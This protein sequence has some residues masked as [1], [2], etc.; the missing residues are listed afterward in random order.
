[1]SRQLKNMGFVLGILVVVLVLV[2][3]F[4]VMPFMKEKPVQ[5]STTQEE[6]PEMLEPED[7]VIIETLAEIRD[8]NAGE[9]SI[10]A[11]PDN[12]NIR[13]PFFWPEEKKQQVE[14]KETG[15]F[16][17]RKSERQKPQLSMVIVGE[18]R[19]KA[20]IDDVFVSEGDMFH[21]YLV[22]RIAPNEVIL[23]DDL[24]EFSI[25]LDTAEENSDQPQPPGGLIEKQ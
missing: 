14:I 10:H 7:V 24:G 6:F 15:K 18:Q 13:N 12:V 4:V 23:S 21:S 3:V 19:R 20:L 16:E 11:A 1:M 5:S 25:H 2:N 8:V 9:S 22:K 17:T